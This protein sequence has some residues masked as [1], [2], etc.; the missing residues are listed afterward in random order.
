MPMMNFKR[1]SLETLLQKALLQRPHTFEECVTWARNHWEVQ[2]ANQIKQLLFNFPPDHDTTSGQPF[3][4]GP[5][6]CPKPLVFDLEDDM[7]LDYVLAGANLMA[8]VYGI[9]G[10]TD[11]QYV[12]DLISNIKVSLLLL[13]YIYRFVSYS[14]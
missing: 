14:Q 10:S 2:Y 6:R 9:Q 11:R 3:W 5:K 13:F 12:A 4:S 7:H 8:N 1:Y